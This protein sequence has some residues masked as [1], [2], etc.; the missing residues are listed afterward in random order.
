MNAKDFNTSLTFKLYTIAGLLFGIYG[1]RVCPMLETLTLKEVLFH[2]GVVY[3]ILFVIRLTVTNLYINK[4][5]A[6][7]IRLDT[8]LFFLISLPF[9]YFYHSVYEFP[10][11]SNLKVLFGMTL[12]GFFT[13]SILHLSYQI[14]DFSSLIKQDQTSINLIGKRHSMVKQMITLVVLLLST[15]AIML[16]MVA[17]KDIHWLE[18]TPE[19]LHDGSGKLSILKEF[20]YI[21]AVLTGYAITIMVLWAK[22]MKKVLLSQEKALIQV[23][24]GNIAARLPIAQ[25]D[26]LGAMATLTNQMLDSLQESQDEVQTTRDVA[27]VSLAALA[28]SRDN[29]T[30]AHILRTQE[31]VKALAIHLSSSEKFSSLLTPSYIDLLYKSAPLH[32]VGKVGIPDAVL[33]KP[34]KLTD[35]EFDIMKGHPQ[36][37]ADALSIA[38]RRMG[39]SSFLKLAREISLSH[40]EKWDGSGYPNSLS[41]E[42]IPLSGRLM[43]LADVYD[44]LISK[45]I[46]K[47]AFSHEK[48]K[49][50]ILEGRGQHFDP[51]VVDAFLSVEEEFKQI[52]AHYKDK[53]Q[54][55]EEQKPDADN[56][57]FA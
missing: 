18:N 57:Q 6:N 19:A 37:G 11:E 1:G 45:R 56:L 13:G 7:F 30:G 8:A 4:Q 15:L 39:S 52:A 20:I 43:A 31:Y 28:E 36:I 38:E 17:F 27:I 35:E 41:G 40:H 55:S 51:E 3:A 46:Y 9:A 21:A 50:I 33:L 49:G 16:S 29:E 24:N 2:T 12:F 26:E 14:K 22:L 32:D 5:N 47:P 44:A 48:A 10:I 54:E 25:N 53:K 42:S 23:T 34:G